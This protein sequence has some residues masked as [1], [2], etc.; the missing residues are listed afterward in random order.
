MTSIQLIQSIW[1]RNHQQA[2][3]ATMWSA[4]M[5]TKQ[6][7]FFLSLLRQEGRL[8]PTNQ[9]SYSL[10]N[11]GG[12]PLE[13]VVYPNGAGFVRVEQWAMTPDPATPSKWRL[14]TTEELA[15]ERSR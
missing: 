6:V 4:R 10:N 14:K 7:N 8:P 1:D 12:C 2:N 9:R 15:H 3:P 11:G 5:T 13:V